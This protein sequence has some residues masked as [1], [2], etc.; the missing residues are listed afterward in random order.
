M[1][2][3]HNKKR[4]TALV[5]EALV[6]ELTKSII[7]KKKDRQK[8]VLSIIKESFRP[9]S[10]LAKELEIY[11]ALYETTDLE[12]STAEKVLTEAKLQYNKLN[13]REIFKQQSGM[14]K[15]INT[16]LSKD[17]YNNF[18][19]NYK[20]IASIYSIFN[21]DA[22]AKEKVLLEERI[23]S[24]MSSSMEIPPEDTHEPIDNIVYRTFVES[25]NKEYSDSLLSEQ[26]LLLNKYISSFAD[27]GLE[28]KLFLNEELGRLKSV[29]KSYSDKTADDAHTAEQLGRVV[30]VLEDYKNQQIDKSMIEDVIKAQQLVREMED[31]N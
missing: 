8:K 3:K 22:P 5:Y 28:L 9:N 27:N 25:F 13:K 12:R 18:V 6:R 15:K 30:E 16:L 10:V 20:N 19:P 17:I 21:F 23:V 7:K 24:H 1:R 4:N 31:D 14:I 11:K 26:A 2:L 29:I